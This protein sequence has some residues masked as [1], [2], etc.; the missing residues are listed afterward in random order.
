MRGPDAAP[1]RTGAVGMML[2]EG[3]RNMFVGRKVQS[4]EVGWFDE[5]PMATKITLESP[6]A[7]EDSE[8]FG[9]KFIRGFGDDDYISDAPGPS[10][11]TP[12]MAHGGGFRLRR[13]DADVVTAL[14][15]VIVKDLVGL[16]IQAIEWREFRDGR[17]APSGAPVTPQDQ[18]NDVKT[19]CVLIFPGFELWSV[20][21]S[22]TSS[23][24]DLMY[25]TCGGDE[26]GAIEANLPAETWAT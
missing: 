1:S 5:Y 26:G 9:F 6:D 15:D 13:L 3:S 10:E 25:I 17:P 19:S 18:R 7:E 2:K 14:D 12:D 4:A 16:T 23:P 24:A 22:S 20:T 21:D 8:E 11:N